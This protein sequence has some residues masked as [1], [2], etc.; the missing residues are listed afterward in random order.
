M[1]IKE[2]CLTKLEAKLYYA[3]NQLEKNSI[4]FFDKDFGGISEEQHLL[5]RSRLEREVEEWKH[6]I[7][8]FKNAEGIR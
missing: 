3:E 2:T 5:V 8:V 6:I 7:K 4:E 1:R